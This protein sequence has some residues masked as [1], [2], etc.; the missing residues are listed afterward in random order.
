MDWIGTAWAVT[1]IVFVAAIAWSDLRSRRIPNIIVF[2]AALVGL[3][4]NLG[5]RGW[6]GLL[7]GLKGLGLAFVLLLIPYM[8]GGM[9]AGDVKFLMAVGAFL[10][11]TDVFRALLATVLCYPVFAAF[12]VIKE[13]KLGAPWVRFRRV[14]WNFPGFFIS[15]LG[16]YAIRLD[17]Q[18]DSAIESVKTPFGVAIAIGS[19]IAA[20]TGFLR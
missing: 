18:D 1:L 7:F 20:F 12:A 9:K 19:L 13:G 10:G 14:W 15:R 16:L 4:F 17:S 2:P 8:V 6:E 3:A 11:A 5:L